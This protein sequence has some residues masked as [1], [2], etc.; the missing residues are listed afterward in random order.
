M[1][2]LGLT[3]ATAFVFTASVFASGTPTNNAK[4]WDGSVN[5]T[6]L[7]NYLNLSSNQA[8]E[9]ATIFDHFEAELKAANNAKKNK[10]AKLRNAV[11]AN[12][13]LMK[14]TLDEKQY[15]SYVRVLGS[16]LRNKG[17]NLN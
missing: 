6:S 17:I 12:L 3:L 15:V 5:R 8:E 2:K 7:N 1:K 10:D 11:Y 4:K 16:T 9:V 14:R 13:K